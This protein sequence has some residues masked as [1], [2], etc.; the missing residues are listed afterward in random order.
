MRSFPV[1]TLFGI[2]TQKGITSGWGL[3]EL[4]AAKTS[5]VRRNHMVL[6]SDVEPTEG[7]RN[8]GVLADL[9]AE[10]INASQNN[11]QVLLIVRS[12]PTW[13][14]V[15]SGS[16]CGPIKQ[17][18]F[19]DFAS[20]MGE[21]V[22]RYSRPPYNVKYWEI[23]NEPDAPVN[24]SDNVYG[25]WGDP[26]D[27]SYYGGRYY[28]EMLKV[29]Y[30]LIKTSDSEAQVV[31]GGLLLDCDPR[32]TPGSCIPSKFLEGILI[33][34]AGNSFDGV[35][36]HA[37]DYYLLEL[38]KYYNP[39]WVSNQE[40]GPVSIAKTRFLKEV[41][42]NYGFPNKFL[43]NTESALICPDGPPGA[44]C[45]LHPDFDATEFEN[46]K[47]YMVPQ[48]YAVA[49]AE[50]L[51]ANV[52][53]SLFGWRH[54][55]LLQW[56]SMTPNPAY[57]AFKFARAELSDAG[58]I[59]EITFTSDGVKGYEFDRGDRHIWVIWLADVD[60]G[61]VDNIDLGGTP[62]AIYDSFGVSQPLAST[63]TVDLNVGP[64]YLEWNP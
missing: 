61:S 13:A 57:N 55:E 46:T 45:Y 35:S 47:A 59:Q 25:C 1:Q 62:L 49:I 41:L 22:A 15:L 52:W 21:L 4:I 32:L 60:A 18:K 26:S 31:V 11:I 29:I 53:Y 36:F 51:R 7:I 30:P 64:L 6:W 14:Q 37:Y 16:F 28:G 12:T 63:I 54:S 19:S 20:F 48:A 17:S 58:F 34:G 3:E 42:A 38:G 24:V 2:E 9:E 10:L 56:P 50:G 44:Y 27:G 33:A 23:W 43:M 40:D 5:W 8:W 39:N